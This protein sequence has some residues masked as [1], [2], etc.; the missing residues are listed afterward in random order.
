MVCCLS[1]SK[2]TM[3]A[4]SGSRHQFVAT[5]K[6]F[7]LIREAFDARATHCS[8]P[9]KK[10]KLYLQY[11][12]SVRLQFSGL[13]DTFVEDMQALVGELEYHSGRISYG[14]CID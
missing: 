7:D 9:L 6:V 8:G 4:Q 1:L 10:L 5:P 2:I 14:I 11:I 3:E 12:N 13:R